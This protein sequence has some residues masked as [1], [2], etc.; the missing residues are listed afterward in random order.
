M[1]KRIIYF[2]IVLLVGLFFSSC[3][4]GH[5]RYY[6]KEDDFSFS[7]IDQ[8][9]S[10]LLIFDNTDTVVYSRCLQGKYCGVEFLIPDSPK[11]IYLMN[12]YQEIRRV[13]PHSYKI[14]LINYDA[15]KLIKNKLAL[16]GGYS[17][18]YG[19]Y[20]REDLYCFAYCRNG[21]FQHGMSP[22]KEEEQK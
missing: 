11:I 17:G 19:G 14:E 1:D 6:C 12:P 16:R 21:E 13:I 4:N 15:Y 5:Y 2:Q 9:D 8:T 18:Y 7:V 3:G 22:I 20:E 10:S